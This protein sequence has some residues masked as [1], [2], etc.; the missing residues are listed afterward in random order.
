MTPK[1][2]IYDYL[3]YFLLCRHCWG[4]LICSDNRSSTVANGGSKMNLNKNIHFGL[5]KSILYTARNEKYN[6]RINLAFT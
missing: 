1:C 3:K 6:I 5:I 4:K 2:Y